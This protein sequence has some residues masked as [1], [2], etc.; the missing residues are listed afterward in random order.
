LH[1]KF[2]SS[3]A[4]QGQST[5][6]RAGNQGQTRNAQGFGGMNFNMNFG[7]DFEEFMGEPFKTKKEQPK[8]NA[9]QMDYSNVSQQF[10][11][12]FGFKPK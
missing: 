7:M 9:S 10:S 6:S 5:N 1:N 4:R 11:S 8:A 2:V 12:F 3:Q